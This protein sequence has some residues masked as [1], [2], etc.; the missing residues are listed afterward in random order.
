MWQNMML[1]HMAEGENEINRQNLSAQVL[2]AMLYFTRI[3]S[4]YYIVLY[5]VCSYLAA[6]IPIYIY[7]YFIDILP[8]VPF[9][10]LPKF[11]LI[12]CITILPC[13]GII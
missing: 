2:V 13:F 9:H 11:Y 12:L 10:I 4:H 3:Y 1:I 5:P 8:C 6:F 7:S